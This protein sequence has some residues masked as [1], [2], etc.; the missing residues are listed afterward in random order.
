MDGAFESIGGRAEPPR[1][2]DIFALARERLERLEADMD[3]I[4]EELEREGRQPIR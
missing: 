4:I 3:L 2:A 1:G